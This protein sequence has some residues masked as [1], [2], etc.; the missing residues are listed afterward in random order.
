MTP[1]ERQLIGDLFERMRSFGAV[2]KDRDADTF[3]AQAMRATPDANYKLVQSVLVQENALQESGARL[4]D[5]EAQVRELQDALAQAQQQQ[6]RPSSGGGSFL[7]GLFG[8][9]KQ[10]QPVQSVPPTS[11]RSAG[12][13]QAPQQRSASPWGGQPQQAP[14]QMG[15]GYAQQP[16]QPQQAAGGGGGFM[17]SAMTTAAGVAGG[18]LAAGAIRDMMSG[19]SAHAAGHSQSSQPS[20]YEVNQASQPTEPEPEYNYQSEETNDPGNTDDST[21]GGSDVDI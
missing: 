1:D 12:F 13:G 6:A 17:K 2:D 4:E 7:G 11:G 21:D 5:L 14:Q 10:A 8:G 18:M 20:P 3:I 9:N 15:G 19:G 16:M